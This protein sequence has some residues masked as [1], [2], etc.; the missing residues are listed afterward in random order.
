[1]FF[2]IQAVIWTVAITLTSGD[3]SH[4]I[5]A[6]Y[7]Q[8]AL[9]WDK[10]K[11]QLAASAKL[12]WTSQVSVEAQGDIR[13]LRQVKLRLLDEQGNP[14]RGAVI[15]LNGFHRAKSRIP[16]QI[17]FTEDQDGNYEGSVIIRKS[18]QWQFDGQAAVGES[19]YIIH[20]ILHL[21]KVVN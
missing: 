17:K 3:E 15:Q 21:Q 2:L 6:N 9:E 7:D 13:G 19:V 5:V 10:Q 20:E 4:S 8:K 1:M 12:G 16:Q 18:G 11:A 14:V